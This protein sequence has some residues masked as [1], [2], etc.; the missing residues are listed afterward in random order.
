M[1]LDKHGDWGILTQPR[2]HSIHG[3]RQIS[4][5]SCC[6]EAS[7]PP[8]SRCEV[9]EN[10]PEQAPRSNERSK[11][12][13][14]FYLMPRRTARATSGHVS[15]YIR[16]PSSKI[17]SFGQ[18]LPRSA[19]ALAENGD[20]NRN[21]IRPAGPFRRCHYRPLHLIRPPDHLRTSLSTVPCRSGQSPVIAIVG[22]PKSSLHYLCKQRRQSFNI[23]KC[24][25]RYIYFYS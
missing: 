17:T 13:S 14:T 6:S 5:E 23:P 20:K 21:I 8:E 1:R 10:G 22:L 7:P 4:Y 24:K 3:P 18:A 15:M 12:L 16:L 11:K 9:T 2:L 19:A 25:Q